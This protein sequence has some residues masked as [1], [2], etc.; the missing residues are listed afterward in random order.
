MLYSLKY[1][2]LNHGKSFFQFE[3]IINV[4]DS[5]FRLILTYEYTIIINILIL[6]VRE[7][8]FNARI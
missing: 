1:F 4:L 6:S 8:P 5:S 2:W 3:S 7:S